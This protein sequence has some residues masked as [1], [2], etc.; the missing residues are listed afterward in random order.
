MIDPSEAPH[1]HG[2][3][4]PRFLDA[5]NH[6]RVALT[7]FVKRKEEEVC[8]CS[9]TQGARGVYVGTLEFG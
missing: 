9:R 4:L 3:W 2:S 1:A 5:R 7:F 6:R 8:E